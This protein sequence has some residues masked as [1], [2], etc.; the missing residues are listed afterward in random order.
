MLKRLVIVA[1]LVAA[2]M[3]PG[4][5]LAQMGGGMGGGGMG[6]PPG[7]GEGGPPGGGGGRRPPR[8]DP[9]VERKQLDGPVKAMFALADGNRDGIVTL[10]ELDAVVVARRQAAIRARFAKIDADHNGTLSDAEFMAWQMAMGSAAASD[11]QAGADPSGPVAETIM[12]ELRNRPQDRALGAVL[13]PLSALVLVEANTNYDGGISLDELLAYERKRFD[14]ADR[15][16]D[17]LLSEQELRAL[18][19]RPAGARDGFGRG[20]R[21]PAD[22]EGPPP[23]MR[24]D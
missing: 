10:A 7:G 13:A 17:G 1:A 11:R 22:G 8:A 19:P 12:P 20:P 16:G 9:P 2:Q 24:G 3:G 18:M 23:P 15:D 6:G 4:L 21:D 5:A 14:K